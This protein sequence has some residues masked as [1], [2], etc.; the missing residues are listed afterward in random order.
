MR[1]AW[2]W[3]L[4]IAAAIVV[5]GAAGAVAGFLWLRTSLPQQD[6]AISLQGLNGP[7]QIVRDRHGIP[8]IHAQSEHD[9]YFALGFVHAQDR[10]W[11][12]DLIRRVGAGRLAE[13]V[14]PVGL[15]SDRLMRVLGLYRL[16]EAALTSL[17]PDTRTALDSYA[18]GVNAYLD[19]HQG[20]WPFEYYLLRTRP[21]PWRPADSLVWGRLMALR[22]Q[23]DFRE[24]LLRARMLQRLTPSQISDLWPSYRSDWMKGLSE[25]QAQ[26]LPAAVAAVDWDSIFAALPALPPHASASNSWAVDG[27]HSKTGKPLLANDPHLALEAPAT[28]YLARIEAPGLVLAGATAAGLPFM[29]LG[30]NANIAWGITSSYIDAQDLFIERID[31]SDPSRYVTPDGTLPFVTRS[32]TIKV[33]GGDDVA[34]TVRETRHGPVISDVTADASE[35]PHPAEGKYV[36]ALADA[37]LR[38]DSHTADA[39][40]GLNHAKNADDITKALQRFDNPSQN[41]IYADRDGNIGLHSVGRVP[42]RKKPDGL[43]PLAGWNGDSDW[44]GIIPFS[45]LPHADNP[46]SGRLIA[47]NNR[48]VGDD[49]P[50]FLSA[51]WP[52][53]Y[54]ARRIAQ[55]LDDLVPLAPAESAAMQLDTVSLAAHDLLPRLLAAPAKGAQTQAARDMLAAWD[56]NMQSNASEPLIYS[57]WLFELARGFFAERLGPF[58]DFYSVADPMVLD[59]ILAQAPTWC[60][61]PKTSSTETCD[62]AISSALERALALL[63][64]SYGN[65]MS[66]WRWG[67][68]HRARFHNAILGEMPLLRRFGNVEIS[69]PGDDSTVNRGTYIAP[70]GGLPFTH[71]H[72]PGLRAVYDLSNLDHSLFMIAPGESGNL[73]SPHYGDF[74]RPW[75]LGQY[76]LLPRG[77]GS[78]TA[79]GSRSLTLTPPSN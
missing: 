29:L 21:W 7:V 13:V 65:D 49:Y 70:A 52:A 56:G 1:N 40:F 6:G 19:Q 64:K 54:R 59:H 34:L 35:I 11:Q 20:A 51:Y 27:A 36:V 15:R 22:L 30:H 55:L 77:S 8:F 66:Q 43:F 14:G 33:R 61:D 76:M 67:D 58:A 48:L 63:G 2:K 38:P 26:T 47:A 17:D 57:A 18:A 16:A 24:E 79:E 23:G 69:T 31:D 42:I 32:E 50:N 62:D 12:M 25:A 41:I 39:F 74:A 45:E 44:T 28:W 3:I 71:L 68:A 9:A 72:G 10:L 60:D 37:G 4:R 73:L 78:A 46:A 75:S 53:P 5:V